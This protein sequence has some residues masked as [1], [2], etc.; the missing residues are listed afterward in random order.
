MIKYSVPFLAKDISQL[1]PPGLFNNQAVEGVIFNRTDLEIP[2]WQLVWKNIEEAI[3]L[4]G[5]ENVTFHFPVNNSDYLEEAFVRKRLVESL[6]KA[7]ELGLHGVVVHSNRVKDID[8]WQKLDLKSERKRLLECLNTVYSEASPTYTWLALENMPIMDNYGKEIDPLF[9]YP[10]DF[11]D[12]E[13]QSVKIVWDIC[14]YTNTLANTWE[15]LQKRQNPDYYPNLR[16]SDYLDFFL[17]RPHIVH[18]HFSAFLGICNPD[19]KNSAKEGVLPDE[20]TL[21]GD[22][23]K[24][25]LAEILKSFSN[26]IEHMVLEIQ[27]EC[28]RERKNIQK[29]LKWVQI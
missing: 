4:Y 17:L 18:W 14:H 21:G 29:M 26:R 7:D 15:V 24:K 3:K 12:W 11:L 16:K 13:N 22:I 8:V 2:T 25:I 10:Q 28:Y 6:Q 23:Y 27:E 5:G 9:I 20:S 1:P 19:L